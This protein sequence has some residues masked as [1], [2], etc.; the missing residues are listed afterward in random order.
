MSTKLGC[1]LNVIDAGCWVKGDTISPFTIVLKTYD[2]EGDR[3]PY[4]IPTG[5]DVTLELRSRDR[6]N[7]ALS[8][9]LGI[10]DLAEAIIELRNPAENWTP[11]PG[12]KSETFF[13]Y[14][15]IAKDDDEGWVG[16]LGLVLREIP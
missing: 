4:P 2:A 11:P 3:I 12:K 10:L 7:E 14:V 8:V 1:D 6:D 16:T 5:A 15:K 13:G 9:E